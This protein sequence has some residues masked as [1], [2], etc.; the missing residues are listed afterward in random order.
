MLQNHNDNLPGQVSG[1]DPR[2]TRVVVGMSGGVDSSVTALLLKEQGFDVIGV[3]MKN[4]DDTDENGVCTATEDFEDVRKVCDTIGIPYYGVNFEQEYMD[5]VFKYFLDEY[6]RGRT[7]NPDVVCNREIKFK[8]LLQAA[9]DLGADFLATGHYAQV[10]SVDGQFQLR[11]AVD[12]NKDQTYFLY[13]VGQAALAK[14]MFPI[15][16]MEKSEV[17]KIAEAA[18]LATAKKKDSTGICFIGERNFR[19]FLSQYLPAQPGPMMTLAG[20]V[21]GEHAGL[22]YYTIGQRHGLGIGGTPGASSNAPWFVVDKDVSRNILYVE[23]GEN[24]PA[25]FK[26]GLVATDLHWVA[27]HPPAESFTCTAKFRYRQ[28]D[29]GVSVRIEADGSCVVDFD[30]PQRAITPGQSVVFYQGPVCLGG[31]VI[32]R[33][34]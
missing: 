1:I 5:R 21:K 16:G 3:F 2:R 8:E 17:R 26:R 15:G 22:M 7:P 20:E 29:Q 12:A 18:G 19:Q 33:A 32:D 23:Q 9:L 24:H 10:A 25:L 14:T 34:L 11:R 6:R 4:W 13:Q 31:G 27:G 30:H 28:P